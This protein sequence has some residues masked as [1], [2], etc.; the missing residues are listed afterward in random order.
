MKKFLKELWTI[1]HPY[2]WR[3]A[4]GVL[5]GLLTG[6]AEPLM[7]VTVYVVFALVFPSNNESAKQL[8]AKA[9]KILQQVQKLVPSSSDFS[10]KDISD[11]PSLA[12][13]LWQPSDAVSGYIKGQLSSET[14]AALASYQGT[15]S[16]NDL[17]RLLAKDLSHVINGPSIYEPKRFDGFVLRF[18]TRKLAANK[19]Q[20]KDL[21]RLNRLLLE[22]AYPLDLARNWIESPSFSIA[23]IDE[24]S[25]FALKLQ[26][27][28]DPVFGYVSSRLSESTRQEL[29]AYEGQGAYPKSLQA[30]LTNDI[31]AI[32]SGPCIFEGARFSHVSLR[33]ETKQL[34]AADPEGK[35]LVRLNRLLLEDAFPSELTKTRVEMATDRSTL[36]ILLVVSTIPIVMAIR[37]IVGYLNIYLMN[38]VSIRAINDLRSKAF[39][40]LLNLPLSFFSK[41][42]TGEL[43]SRVN[44]I[45]ILQ[46][47]VGSSLAVIIRDPVTLIIYVGGLFYYEP[48]LTFLL[49]ILGPMCAVPIAVYNRKVRNSS[50][51]V[52]TNSAGLSQMM[53]ETFSGNRIIK[54]YNLENTVIKQFNS[55]LKASISHYM[56]IIRSQEVPGPLMEFLGSLMAA[57]LIIYFGVFAKSSPA[58]LVTFVVTIFLMYKPL[59]SLTR[60]FNQIE[61][62]KSATERIFQLLATGTTVLEPVKP[63]QLNAHNAD[64]HFDDISFH[65][66]EKP[67]LRNVQLTVK[68]G[69]MVAL[70]GSSGSGKTTM[71]NLILRF[72]DPQKGAI[73]INGTDIREVTT[74]DLRNQIA[75]VTQ[76]SILFND[77]IYNNI[78]LGRP[79]ATKEE[80]MAA[81]KHAHAHEFISQKPQGYQ[82]RIGDRGEAL[83][84]GQR[85]RIAIARAILRDTPILVLDEATS[86]LD[87]ESERAVQAAL[88]ELMKGRTTICIAH[89]LSTIRNADLIVVMDHGQI[90]E[91]GKH[92]E[93][94]KQDGVYH[95]LYS[96][97][98]RTSQAAAIAGAGAGAGVAAMPTA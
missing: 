63:K 12:T 51:A 27:T 88:D 54:A 19:P 8:P 64:I 87:T 68:P 79:G 31:E 20:G 48:K 84:G 47:I 75:I 65:Y 9:Q 95:K 81:A 83:S 93:L 59:K 35:N 76:E 40:H 92:D 3:L 74:Q 44:D 41:S 13:K 10:V 58:H 52:Q 30:S 39:A 6:A 62:A 73:R 97:Q 55:E 33:P 32:L 82:T 60:I 53:H 17:Q 37:G 96:L 7:L 2:K 26:D 71:T 77:T 67:V 21:A 29:A 85:Q 25:S 89:R 43:M 98:F 56:R 24:P 1:W 34:L 70:V 66:G 38:W 72:Y 80:I 4:G 90:V 61:L 5:C 91:M 18:E 45:N 57:V 42:S 28:S 14:L 78:A 36:F 50:A 22:D 69:Q 15:N 49:L 46:S 94:L 11:V 16:S 86:A 23:D